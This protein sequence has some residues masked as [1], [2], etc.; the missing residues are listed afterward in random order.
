MEKDPCHEAALE[1]LGVFKRKKM[2]IVTTNY[3]L[4]ELVALLTSFGMQRRVLLRHLQHIQLDPMVKII[5]VDEELEK[6]G[7]K[8]LGNRLDKAWS[9]VDAIGFVVMEERGITEALST[10]KHFAQA[11]FVPLLMPEK[12]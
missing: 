4:C 10:D 5:H 11:S 3:V 1:W 8:L 2:S 6:K 7:W 9:L 12:V